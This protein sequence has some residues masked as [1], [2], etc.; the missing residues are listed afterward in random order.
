MHILQE[1]L[2]LKLFIQWWL[3]LNG[4]LRHGTAIEWGVYCVCRPVI[5]IR[6][7]VSVLRA[8]GLTARTTTNLCNEANYLGSCHCCLWLILIDR[9]SCVSAYKYNRGTL[10]SVWFT[11]AKT[12]SQRLFGCLPLLWTRTWRPSWNCFQPSS[13][14]DTAFWSVV[15]YWM[16]NPSMKL[17]ANEMPRPTVGT[18]CCSHNPTIRCKIWGFHGGDYEE[19]RLLGSYAVLLL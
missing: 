8:A 2:L 5:I 11:P 19:W 17:R 14:T 6:N 12:S 9:G 13:E 3:L 4:S 10:A 7:C 1:P 15:K 18:C 16:I